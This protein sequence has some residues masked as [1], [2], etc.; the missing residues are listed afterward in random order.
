[1]GLRLVTAPSLEP[2][3]VAQA[4]K[5]LRLEI[6]DDDEYVGDVIT[7]ARMYFERATNRSLNTQTWRLT[8]DDFPPYC[9][10]R[11]TISYPFLREGFFATPFDFVDGTTQ[12]IRLPMGQVQS[13]TSITYL[14]T[15]GASTAFTNY[16]LDNSE[17]IARLVP[18]YNYEWPATRGDI[19][20]VTID[21][22]T[23][24][25]A[26]ATD[27]PGDIRHA[28]KTLIAYW[29]DGDRAAVLASSVTHPADH[30]LEAVISSYR[31]LTARAA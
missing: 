1:M 4:K 5:H 19:A 30:A 27:V 28:I 6:A 13:V 20:S 25:G 18:A 10:Q 3:T 17:N 8:L 26:L 21:Y 2:V 12:V 29:Y 15:S 16:R 24:Y 7:A 14:D 9:D 22:V 11:G 31:I 23:G